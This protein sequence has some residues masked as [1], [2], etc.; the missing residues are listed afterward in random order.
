MDKLKNAGYNINIRMWRW[1]KLDN[2]YIQT[3]SVREEMERDFTGSI[4]RLARIGYAGVEFAG[5]YGGLDVPGM[6][7][8]LQDNGLDCISAHIG[9]D[10]TEE[11]IDYMAGI[12]ARY[13]ICPSARVND[14]ESAMVAVGELNRLGAACKK[15][16]LK[17][18]YH[19]HTSEFRTHAGK[20]LLEHMI[21]NTDPDTVVFQLDVGWC[22]T[23]GA[24]AVAFI[25]K[26]A[27]RFELIHAKEA[28]EVVGTDDI[29]DF[30][31]VKF[32]EKGHPIFTE[33]IKAAFAER[34]RMNVP[35][36]KGLIDWAVIK[37]IAD[38]QGAKAYIVEREWDYAGD[39]FRCVEEDWA[40]LSKL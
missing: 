36:G 12:G 39:L 25:Q 38:A 16:G 14:Y 19:N 32:D 10:K 4:E 15:A 8:L 29:I 31:K 23:A 34:M 26:H 6:K 21:E 9:F 37:Q 13:I 7:A 3:Y 27:G 24:D 33:E 22:V 18:G 1:E 28:G 5:N 11:S 35:T 30:S 17:Y 20:Y 40:F 2:L